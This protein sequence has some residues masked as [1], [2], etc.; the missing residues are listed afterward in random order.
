MTGDPW[1][2]R[3]LEWAT[4]SPPPAFNFAV[5]PDVDGEDA[6]WAMKQRAHRAA[7][8]RAT[9][10][11]TADIE[12]PRNSADRLRLRLL[13]DR[14]RLRAD[15]AH[16]VDGRPRASSAPIATFVVFAWRDDDEYEIPAEEVARI[17]RANRSARGAALAHRGGR[18]DDRCHA[19]VRAG[20]PGTICAAMPTRP[21]M[22][23]RRAGA[24]SASSSATASG[25][26][27]SAT[28]SCSPRFFA[29]L[30][31]A[32]RADRRRPERRASCST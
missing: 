25:S 27:C 11:P 28:S 2:G 26:S 10:R 15:L 5:L 32:A 3:T 23:A 8:A 12:M 14:H 13:R 4:A 18:H 19:A 17:D 16:L 22:R 20:R 6:Y 21:A 1:D 24:R 29:S 9:S 7:G 30:C 31:G